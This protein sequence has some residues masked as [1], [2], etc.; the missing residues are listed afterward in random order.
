[1]YFPQISNL[2]P[3]KASFNKSRRSIDIGMIVPLTYFYP[4]R[5]AGAFLPHGYIF[6]G[7]G[8]TSNFTHYTIHW[9]FHI[10]ET[11]SPGFV[12]NGFQYKL[13]QVFE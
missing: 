9:D 5:N 13:A 4:G 3:A 2:I 11:V 1:M 10:C 12:P 6:S 7:W 8:L